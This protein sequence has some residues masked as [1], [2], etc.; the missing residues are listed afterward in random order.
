[1][2]SASQPSQVKLFFFFSFFFFAVF[3]IHFCFLFFLPGPDIEK[4]KSL[5][6][7]ECTVTKVFAST[8]TVSP[9]FVFYT[10]N[11][12]L[13][14][15]YVPQ[16]VSKCGFSNSFHS[17]AEPA[18]G[19]KRVS[20]ENLDAIRARFLEMYV[21]KTPQQDPRDL[22]TC[23]VFSRS[24]FILGV[25]NRALETLEKY[26]ATDFHSAH[27]PAYALS[28]LLKNHDEM[29][30]IMCCNQGDGLEPR[31]DC[32]S[33]HRERLQRLQEKFQFNP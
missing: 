12:R 13:F 25:Y 5:S 18:Q 22:E 29:E 32:P 31:P 28:A 26:A 4:L 27:L 7:A 2:T 10:S 15:H 21:F 9:M 24:A 3:L 23:G 1:M 20:Q 8:V 6:R 11:E 14:K 16:A 30:S 19:N 17:Q 33:Q